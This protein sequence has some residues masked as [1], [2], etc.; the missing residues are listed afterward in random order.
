MISTHPDREIMAS[1]S[2]TCPVYH[3]DA[4]EPYV[5]HYYARRLL[6]H[7]AGRFYFLTTLDTAGPF[8]GDL[9]C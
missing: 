5:H 4:A 2:S 8:Q 6:A 7:P 3:T 1:I 9:G